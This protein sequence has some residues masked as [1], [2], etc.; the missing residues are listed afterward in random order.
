MLLLFNPKLKGSYLLF[1][2]YYM[3]GVLIFALSTRLSVMVFSLAPDKQKETPGGWVI[4]LRSFRDR[5]DLG[6][7]GW[8]AKP[9]VSP[10]AT[11]PWGKKSGMPHLHP[12]FFHL[13]LSADHF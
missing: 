11:H 1:S 6:Q 2:T 5:Q 10:S 12:C 13:I 8:T 9:E 7:D 4:C 3:M